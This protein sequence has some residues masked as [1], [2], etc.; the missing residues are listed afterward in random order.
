ML[1]ATISVPPTHRRLFRVFTTKADLR[2]AVQEYDA[3]ST[4][5]IARYGPIAGW[6]VSAITDMSRLFSELGNFNADISSW[7]TSR[8]TDMRHMLVTR[9]VSQL[10]MSALK[11]PNS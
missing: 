9:D 10:E 8:V 3:N 11:L 7:D 2:T 1:L 4:D 6:D 5:A